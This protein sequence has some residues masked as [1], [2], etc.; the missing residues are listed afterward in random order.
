[1]RHPLHNPSLAPVGFCDVVAQQRLR[2]EPHP[3][4]S[5]N[6]ELAIAKFWAGWN[7]QGASHPLPVAT[8]IHDMLPAM[9]TRFR[10]TEGEFM[11]EG[12]WYVGRD[13]AVLSSAVQWFGSNVGNC[14]LLHSPV[15]FK[16]RSKDREFVEK[17]AQ[18]R[19]SNALVMRFTHHACTEAC[20]RNPE[21]HEV[22]VG[23][24]VRDLHD[25]APVTERDQALVEGLMWWLG[26]T[27]GRSFIAA[28]DAKRS[29]LEKAARARFIAS[30]PDMVRLQIER[31]GT[32]RR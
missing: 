28:W 26:R 13:I 32:K 10:M 29:R 17:F 9:S 16:P 5:Y 21:P 31:A 11:F 14:F 7:R 4:W 30:Y 8:I 1:M 23:F 12:K 15:F 19:V 24:R 25:Y 27:Q 18:E 3:E 6:P 20:G 2:A 22:V